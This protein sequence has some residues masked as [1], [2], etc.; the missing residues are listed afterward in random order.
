MRTQRSTSIRSEKGVALV[1][2]M[3]LLAVISA[4]T[5]GLAMSGQTEVAAM[6]SNE[7]YYAGARAS[8]EAGLNRATEHLNDVNTLNLLAGADGLVDAANPGAAV[9]ADNGRVPTIGNGP[10]TLSNGFAYTLQI[11]T[12]TTIRCSMPLPLTAGPGGRSAT[13]TADNPCAEYQR[14]SDH[15]CDRFWTERAPPWSS[16]SAPAVECD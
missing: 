14:S 3:L 15:S 16:Y 10:F 9:N 4:L 11:L 2:V 7:M 5:T 8:A 13:R 1:I 12:T 6:A